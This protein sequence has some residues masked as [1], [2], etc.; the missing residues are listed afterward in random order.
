MALPKHARLSVLLVMI[1]CF[2]CAGC[3]VGTESARPEG[4]PVA[5]RVPVKDSFDFTR[6]GEAP[7]PYHPPPFFEDDEYRYTGR[8][9]T[10]FELNYPSQ[11]LTVPMV[12]PEGP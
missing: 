1:A 2:L 4:G 8:W 6:R 12:P 9:L 7:A 3:A 5:V 10:I 11:T